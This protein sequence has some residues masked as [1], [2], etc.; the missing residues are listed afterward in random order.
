MQTQLASTFRTAQ[1]FAGRVTQQRSAH[2]NGTAKT[3]SR[4]I[5]NSAHSSTTSQ[6]SGRRLPAGLSTVGNAA[7]RRVN[8]AAVLDPSPAGAAA[9]KS[10]AAA[11]GASNIVGKTPVTSTNAT[12]ATPATATKDSAPASEA[13]VKNYIAK[14]GTS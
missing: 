11:K 2:S 9:E 5:V 8:V 1:P 6:S 12:T 3:K 14:V 10:A 7:R 13:P 4:G